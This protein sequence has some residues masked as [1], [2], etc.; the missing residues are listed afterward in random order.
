MYVEFEHLP[1]NSKIWIYQA[2][3]ELSQFEQEEINLAFSTYCNQWAAHG[4]PLKASG[5]I[6]YDRFLILAVDESANAVSGCSIDES[7]YFVKEL[8]HKMK[9]DF[10]NR[11]LVTFLNSQNNQILTVTIK[12]AKDMA[13]QN[14]IENDLLIFN[15]F[16]LEKSSLKNGWLIPVKDSWLNKW[17]PKNLTL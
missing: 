10:L 4:H 12:K 13:A 8:S 15:N 1:G 6:L 3:R 2:D 7:V 17:M 16:I 14:S 9:I 11:D 5:K